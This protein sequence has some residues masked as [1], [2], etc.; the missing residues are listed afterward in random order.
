[1]VIVASSW[2]LFFSCHNDAR[3]STLQNSYIALT[4]SS[5]LVT[6]AQF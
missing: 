5:V 6:T 3:S 1:V 4:F 2:F